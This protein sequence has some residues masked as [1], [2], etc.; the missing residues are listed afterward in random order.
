MEFA[1][2]KINVWV[3]RKQ[4]HIYEEQKKHPMLSKKKKQFPK[5]TRKFGS[6]LLCDIIVLPW[7]QKNNNFPHVIIWINAFPIT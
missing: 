2:R 6:T 4:E 3:L 5:H 7:M 1:W